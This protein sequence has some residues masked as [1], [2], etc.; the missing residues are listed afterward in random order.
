MVDRALLPGRPGPAGI[1]AAVTALLGLAVGVPL[2]LNA[3]ESD[4]V[5]TPDKSNHPVVGP[6]AKGSLSAPSAAPRQD[7]I[8]ANDR[9]AELPEVAPD[10]GR[11][12]SEGTLKSL[13]DPENVAPANPQSPE[14][15]VVPDGIRVAVASENP[16]G[17]GPI[18][19]ASATNAER[20]APS[21][22]STE[23]KSVSPT[24]SNPV[25]PPPPSI[26]ERLNVPIPEFELQMPVTLKSVLETVEIM[27]GIRV[28]LSAELATA[29]LD[30]EVVFSLENTSPREILN[31]A[32]SRVGLVVSVS[33]DRVS[34]KPADR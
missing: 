6:A 21:S 26:D 13:I 8:V 19:Q 23:R 16:A 30:R 11:G 2:L 3:P 29:D 28:D 27:A 31:E 34:L 20:G 7:S 24:P 10:D 12:S 33:G 15:S 1:A 18:Q 32:A 25:A 14:I 5:T 17:K 9:R 22:E 4:S